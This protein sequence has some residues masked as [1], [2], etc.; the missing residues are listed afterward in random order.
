MNLTALKACRVC[1]FLLECVDFVLI[2]MTD[3]EVDGCHVCEAAW[4]PP[5]VDGAVAVTTVLLETSCLSGSDWS[6]NQCA[7]MD[8]KSVL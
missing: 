8:G 1:S 3:L 6:K 5:G 4:G 7:W 2:I